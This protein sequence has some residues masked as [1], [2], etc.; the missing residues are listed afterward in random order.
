MI[1]C[2]KTVVLACVVF[3]ALL[4]FVSCSTIYREYSGSVAVNDRCDYSEVICV[5]NGNDIDLTMEEFQEVFHEEAL[6]IGLD[7]G[8]FTLLEEAVEGFDSLDAW[9]VHVVETMLPQFQ[10]WI[11]ENSGISK[12]N[13][14]IGYFPGH[15]LSIVEFRGNSFP[16]VFFQDYDELVEINLGGRNAYPIS[17]RNHDQVLIPLEPL[18]DFLSL[19][20]SWNQDTEQLSL[21]GHNRDFLMQPD[22]E[23]VTVSLPGHDDWYFHN[24]NDLPS[25]LYSKPGG[26]YVHSSLLDHLLVERESYFAVPFQ[27]RLFHVLIYHDMDKIVI[28]PESMIFYPHYQ[29]KRSAMELQFERASF[30]IEPLLHL[31]HFKLSTGSISEGEQV[32]LTS[33]QPFVITTDLFDYIM[34]PALEIFALLEYDT[35]S[36]VSNTSIYVSISGED[37]LIEEGTHIFYN[38]E[39]IW[40]PGGFVM[41]NEQ[42]PLAIDGVL[43]VSHNDLQRLLMSEGIGIHF[44]R[45]TS[46]VILSVFVG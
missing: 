12:R 8:M 40:L 33:G 6:A 44:Y 15:D 45:Q 21:V 38:E 18:F 32:E 46:T 34:L 24:W 29:R 35:T 17:H 4:G 19:Q 26:L 25:I 10:D 13:N 20:F 39:P 43:F 27:E 1:V 14:I 9:R 22:T 5:T 28:V 23:G 31:K 36:A 11:T 3:I 37:F 16:R 30:P 42:T 7:L 41:L 2:K